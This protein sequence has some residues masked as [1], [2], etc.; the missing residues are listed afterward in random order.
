LPVDLRGLES[1][2]DFIDR[3]LLRLTT[4][5]EAHRPLL[6]HLPAAFKD[7][8][9]FVSTLKVNIAGLVEFAAGNKGLRG[10]GYLPCWGSGGML[11]ETR[12]DQPLIPRPVRLS[13]AD[14]PAI[15]RIAAIPSGIE[16]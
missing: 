9:A 1:V 14:T 15:C 6:K 11:F 8:L 10:Y 7:A 4:Q 5:L 16:L 12:S 13:C 3:L 2:G